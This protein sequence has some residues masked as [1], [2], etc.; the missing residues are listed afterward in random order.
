MNLKW[1]SNLKHFEAW[2]NGQT[3]VPFIDANMRELKATGFM[4]NRGR[5]NVASFLT[6]DLQIEWWWGAMYFESMLVDYDVC[7]NWGNWNYVAG[8]GNDPRPNR[9]F[10]ILKQAS[11]YD[12]DNS[13][14]KHWCPELTGLDENYIQSPWK[15][16]DLE[17][18]YPKPIID[19]SSWK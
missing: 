13:F 11:S 9:Y 8:I 1:K 14:V 17:I 12:P 5:Q 18:N 6:K 19:V 2:C 4:S 7:S 10:N 3:G 16:E 15:I